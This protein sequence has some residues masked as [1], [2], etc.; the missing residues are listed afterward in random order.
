MIEKAIDIGV[1]AI[2]GASESS[3]GAVISGAIKI[4]V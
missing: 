2:D 4:T 3:P 1:V